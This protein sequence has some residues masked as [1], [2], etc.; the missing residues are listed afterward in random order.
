MYVLLKD[1]TEYKAPPTD[2]TLIHAEGCTKLLSVS[3]PGMTTIPERCFAGCT[4][5]TH[6]HL[7]PMVRSIGAGCFAGCTSLTSITLPYGPEEVDP[8]WFEGCT[9][10]TTIRLPKSYKRF[11]SSAPNLSRLYIKG[12]KLEFTS[13]I[14][15]SLAVIKW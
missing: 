15:K 13:P 1:M 3:V 11:G 2:N 7:A 5:L 12:H 8:S 4:S 9:N 6:V 10:L 14:P